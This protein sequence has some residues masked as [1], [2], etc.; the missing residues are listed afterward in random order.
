MAIKTPYDMFQERLYEIVLVLTMQDKK[1]WE[2]HIQPITGMKIELLGEII[3][4]PYLQFNNLQVAIA[5]LK[6]PIS[7]GGDILSKTR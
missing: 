7:R 5:D 2:Q 4:K 3:N 1:V 6:K